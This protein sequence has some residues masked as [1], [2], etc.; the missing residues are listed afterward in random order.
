MIDFDAAVQ[1]V[2]LLGRGLVAIDGL[3]VSGKSTL[4]QRLEDELGATV[5]YLD[6]FVRPEGEWRGSAKPGFPF[7]YFRYD[8]FMAAVI[9]LAE[10]RQ[11]RYRRYDWAAGRLSDDW[12]VLRPDGLVVVEGVSS[13]HPRLAPRYDLRLWVESDAS[14]TLEASLARGVGDWEDAWRNLFMPSVALYLASDPRQRADYCVAG[15]GAVAVQP[16][17]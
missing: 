6:D 4:A 10:G 2:R 14:T 1:Q 15:R 9:D 13:L 11:A 12:H 7:P 17:L 3:P 8:E 5:L 16:F